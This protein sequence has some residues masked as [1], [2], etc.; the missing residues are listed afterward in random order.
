[1]T[2]LAN[3]R[4]LIRY[5]DGRSYEVLP[6]QLVSVTPVTQPLDE[7]SEAKAQMK[8][9]EQEAQAIESEK[10]NLQTL[11]DRFADKRRRT[12]LAKATQATEAAAVAAR[13]LDAAQEAKLQRQRAK[14]GLRAWFLVREQENVGKLFDSK[15]TCV[16]CGGD[17]TIMLYENG[18]WA[19][20]SGLP[21]QLWNK[22][23]GRQK[24]LPTPDYVALGSQDRLLRPLPRRE[25]SQWVGCDAMSKALQ[26]SARTVRSVAFGA[27]FDAY[28]IVYTDGFWEYGGHVPAG[29]V[30]ALETN[31]RRPNLKCVSLGPTGEYF[32]ST[33]N[34]SS[35]VGV[36]DMDTSAI[37][38]K[39]TY[40]D[41]GANGTYFCRHT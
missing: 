23:N 30:E 27:S 4:V 34:R 7:E 1:M 8:R 32:V 13:A 20:S 36:R 25:I 10:R 24:S 38:N 41:F 5:D 29:L 17:A 6:T 19:C 39:I 40:M 3:G 14:R 33:S 15:V 16:A 35:W 31:E 12:D 11:L 9:L 37:R 26:K 22:L 21:T 28:F 18:A 2:G